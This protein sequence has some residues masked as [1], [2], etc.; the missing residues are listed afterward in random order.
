M[1]FAENL[2]L[3]DG[4]APRATWASGFLRPSLFDEPPFVIADLGNTEQCGGK[5]EIETGLRLIASGNCRNR[6]FLM[7]STA[8]RPSAWDSWNDAIAASTYIE[9]PLITPRKLLTSH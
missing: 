9:E 8:N 6:A 2:G 4:Y 1:K 3:H 7:V 5:A